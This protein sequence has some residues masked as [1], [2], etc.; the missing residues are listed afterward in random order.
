MHTNANVV[1]PVLPVPGAKESDL[2]F[3]PPRMSQVVK[4]SQFWCKDSGGEAFSGL[5]KE[6]LAPPLKSGGGGQ[7]TG[8]REEQMVS[9]GQ[10]A[11]RGG[12]SF[13]AFCQLLNQLKKETEINTHVWR[14]NH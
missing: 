9:E 11:E 2:C 14:A 12:H 6:S 8:V 7:G 13:S 10:G 5:C 4:G 3:V 1:S